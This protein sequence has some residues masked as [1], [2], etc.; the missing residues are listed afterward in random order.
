MFLLFMWHQFYSALSNNYINVN[1]HLLRAYYVIAL[2]AV[3]EPNHL[4]L[5]K[6]LN[7]IIFSLI[8]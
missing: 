7:S 2:N 6:I 4:I 5:M 1:Q 8:L 3:H